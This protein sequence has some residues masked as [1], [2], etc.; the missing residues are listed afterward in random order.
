MN[1]EANN[2]EKTPFE[3]W[4]EEFQATMQKAREEQIYAP[5][6]LFIVNREAQELQH[7]MNCI[8]FTH[9]HKVNHQEGE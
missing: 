5:D 4:V 2:Q 7:M 3:L 8:L 1:T 6:V 9:E